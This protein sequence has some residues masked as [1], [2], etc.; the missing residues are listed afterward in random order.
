MTGRSGGR[1]G[2]SSDAAR[3]A[4]AG[5]ARR[6]LAGAWRAATRAAADGGFR[7]FS[8][9]ADVGLDVWGRSLEALF[10]W[11][12]TGFTRVA[13]G[14]ATY[15]ATARRTTEVRLEARDCEAL[16][17]DWLNHLLLLS[18]AD[19]LGLA[20]S[21]IRIEPGTPGGPADP[22]GV[23][24]PSQ[25]WRLS[26]TLEVSALP[27]GTRRGIVKAATYHGLR[28]CRGEDGRFRARVLLD[29]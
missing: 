22:G 20:G 25:P 14:A 11:A 12:A 26:G 15:P 5:R 2:K 1:E 27:P 3:A 29:I 4:G 8:H 9:T 28:V 7:T 17:V 6:P 16:L 18:E 10:S 21:A 24:A 19:G 23:G 13:T